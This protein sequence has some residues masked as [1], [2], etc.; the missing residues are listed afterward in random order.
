MR[1]F[2]KSASETAPNFGVNVILLL[3]GGWGGESVTTPPAALA[4][5]TV[6]FIFFAGKSITF[7]ALEFLPTHLLIFFVFV[8][9]VLRVCN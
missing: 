2:R 7:L 3:E 1:S 6:E 9:R 8:T 5:E 4:N